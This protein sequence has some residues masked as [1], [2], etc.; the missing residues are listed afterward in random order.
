MGSKKKHPPR[1]GMDYMD[2]LS[3]DA[4]S[5]KAAAIQEGVQQATDAISCVLHDP[6]VM[7]HDTF[8]EKRMAKI[9]EAAEAKLN[10]YHT[11]FTV[12]KEAD[13]Y[14]EKLDNELRPIFGK[15]FV[16]FHGRHPYVPILDYKEAHKGWKD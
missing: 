4:I 13:Y 9:I 15:R 2:R 8:G 12:G 16:P 1:K 3:I 14:Q 5:L 6:E 10:Y 7:G 11:A